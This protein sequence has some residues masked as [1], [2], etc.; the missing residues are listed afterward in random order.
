MAISGSDRPAYGIG[1]AAEGPSAAGNVCNHALA[2]W[3]V[4]EAPCRI[5]GS[6]PTRAVPSF[7]PSNFEGT[8][9]NLHALSPRTTPSCQLDG[10]NLAA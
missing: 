6:M 4:W 2:R 8:E 10:E 5:G 7:L 1:P 3:F 9:V